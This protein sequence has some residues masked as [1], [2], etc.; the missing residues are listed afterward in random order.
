MSV[1]GV[2]N[3]VSRSV[4]IPAIRFNLAAGN[5]VTLTVTG[6]SMAPTLKDKRD[7]VVLEPVGEWPPRPGA[8]LFIQRA[9]GSPVMH[10]VIRVVGQSVILN[11]DGQIWIEG[12]IGRELAIARV[13]K[14]QRKNKTIAVNSAGFRLYSWVWI[15]LRPLRRI[16]FRTVALFPRK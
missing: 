9:D 12:P 10:R 4:A 14:L 16:I 11:G 6:G 13:E 5:S 2:R 7:Q 1:E 8:I 3:S 15:R